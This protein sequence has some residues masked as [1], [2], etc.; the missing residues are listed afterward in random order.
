MC[1]FLEICREVGEAPP[2]GLI[3]KENSRRHGRDRTAWMLSERIS[4][5]H[6]NLVAGHTLGG[7]LV[8]VAVVAQQGVLLAG[9][10]LVG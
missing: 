3:R 9:E 6:D 1:C 5:W 2:L 4:T 8:T 10:W 7:K